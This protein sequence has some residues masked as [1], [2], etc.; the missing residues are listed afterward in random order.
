MLQQLGE[1]IRRARVDSGLSQAQLGTPHFTRAYVSAVEL[2]KV[3]PAMKSLEFMA[4]KLGKP[5]SFFMEDEDIARRR[6]ERDAVAAHAKQLVSEGKAG[7]AIELL[8][9]Q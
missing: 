7:E 3:R 8:L 2:G 6:L 1:R 9:P 5:V 4:G